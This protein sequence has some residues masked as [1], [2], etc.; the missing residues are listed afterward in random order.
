MSMVR[1][2]I[3]ITAMLLLFGGERELGRRAGT[4]RFSSCAGLR[5]E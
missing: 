5:K 2:A 3:L 4:V 1:F